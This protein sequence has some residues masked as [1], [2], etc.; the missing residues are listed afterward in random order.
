MKMYVL[1]FLLKS[2]IIC[3][4][5]FFGFVQLSLWCLLHLLSGLI[6][7]IGIVQVVVLCYLKE[8]ELLT[9]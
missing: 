7:L 3:Y 8:F 9:Y 5:V 2:Y 6:V 4:T 1:Q